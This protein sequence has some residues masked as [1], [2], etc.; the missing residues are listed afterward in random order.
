MIDKCSISFIYVIISLV[1]IAVL[2]YLYVTAK[3]SNETFCTCRN[4]AN[5][6]CPDPK[7]LSDL[8]YE[9]ILTESTD[10]NKIKNFNAKLPMP[11][12]QFARNGYQ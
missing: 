7:I 10:L 11:D 9:G 12:D 5:K 8:Y 1:I 4:M 3:K 2:I 6:Y